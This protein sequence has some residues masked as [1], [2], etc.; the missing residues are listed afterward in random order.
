MDRMD[1][2]NRMKTDACAFLLSLPASGIGDF[3]LFIPATL[4][5]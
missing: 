1:G 3:I 4:S 5:K 2:M